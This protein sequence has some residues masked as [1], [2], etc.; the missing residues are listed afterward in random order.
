MIPILGLPF[1]GCLILFTV[2]AIRYRHAAAQPEQM[3]GLG[4]GR[5][6]AG[7]LGVMVAA[8]C[9]AAWMMWGQLQWGLSSGNYPRERASGYAVELFLFY[10]ISFGSIV[11]FGLTFLGLQ[12]MAI[13]RCLRLLSALGLG[14]TAA[15][16]TALLWWSGEPMAEASVIPFL[17]AA[18]FSAAARLPLV[19]S[20]RP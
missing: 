12:F 17:L 6:A 1:L 20:P 7:Y 5:I 16:A 9:I 3:L 13:L 19:N 2:V 14:L 10:F 15:L 8:L 18:G 11:I 4:L